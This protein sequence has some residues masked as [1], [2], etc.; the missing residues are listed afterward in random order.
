M[1]TMTGNLKIRVI[2]YTTNFRNIS[3]FYILSNDVNFI[4][5]FN[6]NLGATQIITVITK[7][8]FIFAT[9]KTYHSNLASHFT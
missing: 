6:V 7:S 1:F 4:I 3:K 5:N 9:Q 2:Y 8:H